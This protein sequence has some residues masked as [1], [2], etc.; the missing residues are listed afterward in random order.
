MEANLTSQAGSSAPLIRGG[1][2]R[3][4]V[5]QPQA[6]HKIHPKNLNEMAKVCFYLK[7][8]LSSLLLR[9]AGSE[10]RVM[11]LFIYLWVDVCSCNDIFIHFPKTDWSPSSKWGA[12]I[13]LESTYTIDSQGWHLAVFLLCFPFPKHVGRWMERKHYKASI[14]L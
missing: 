3:F 12:F 9:Q 6:S 7:T 11:F 1:P 4:P 13:C 5:R 2:P 8:L 10:T 14:S